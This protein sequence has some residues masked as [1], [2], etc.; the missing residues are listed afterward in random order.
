M[1]Q[2]L[3]SSVHPDDPAQALAR[4]E[5]L[6]ACYQQ[7]IGHDLPNRLVVLQGTARMLE[8]DA[9]ERLDPALRADLVRLAELARRVHDFI[10][11]LADVGRTCRRAEPAEEVSLEEVC[12]EAAA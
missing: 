8:Q 11:A 5:R 4:A 6:L 2:P 9:G 12:R 1:E 10:A 7:A 3:H